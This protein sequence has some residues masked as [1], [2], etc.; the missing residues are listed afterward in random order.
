ML[1]TEKENKLEECV[2]IKGHK[3]VRIYKAKSSWILE[4]GCQVNKKDKVVYILG[5]D[6]HISNT[7][8]KKHAI[9]YLQNRIGDLVNSIIKIK[10]YDDLEEA[11][12]EAKILLIKTIEEDLLDS[13]KKNK[14]FR[15]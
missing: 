12:E 14:N 6:P 2:K 8:C 10:D 5:C 9:E 11:K 3:E 13:I 1:E 4:C 15:G 7:S